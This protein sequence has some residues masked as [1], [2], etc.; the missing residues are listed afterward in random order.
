MVKTLQLEH[1][2]KVPILLV[3]CSSLYHDI[4]FQDKNRSNIHQIET[5]LHNFLV[6]FSIHIH[7]KIS[8]RRDTPIGPVLAI[9]RKYF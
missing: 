2:M 5:V 3:Q 9:N 6:E 4:K 7:F 8:G 1:I